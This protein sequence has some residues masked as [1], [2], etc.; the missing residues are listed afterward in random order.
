MKEVFDLPEEI[1]VASKRE[2]LCALLADLRDLHW[3]KAVRCRTE[4]SL[5]IPISVETVLSGDVSFLHGYQIQR[6][7]AAAERACKVYPSKWVIHLSDNFWYY[8]AES[9]CIMTVFIT[10]QGPFSF[11]I[12]S[13]IIFGHKFF[14]TSIFSLGLVPIG[15]QNH[16]V[17]VTCSGITKPDLPWQPRGF[18]FC[19]IYSDSWAQNFK[20]RSQKG[21]GVHDVSSLVRHPY[22]RCNIGQNI[23]YGCAVY[24]SKEESRNVWIQPF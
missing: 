15:I 11:T 23:L 10:L 7:V 3:A 1:P 9:N 12:G 17:N 18:I 13:S 16:L 5:M 6:A 24:L 8:M 2:L 21:I 22:K 14:L 4:L 19:S 20:Q